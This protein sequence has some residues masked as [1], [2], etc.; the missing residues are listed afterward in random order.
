MQ[1]V[2][3]AMSSFL[4]S[5]QTVEGVWVQMNNDM[6]S[7]SNSITEGN[8]GSIPFLVKAKASLAINSWKAVDDSAKQFTVESLVDYT[9]IAFGDKLPA[10]AVTL[11]AAA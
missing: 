7:I 2:G 6:L 3:P 5:L 11:A 1:R 10:N 9:S 8:V 4:K